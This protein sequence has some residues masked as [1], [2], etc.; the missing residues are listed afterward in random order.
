M[1]YKVFIKET[2]LHNIES[3]SEAILNISESI[4]IAERYIDGLYK[5]IQKLS[6]YGISL[7]FCQNKDVVN[8]YGKYIRRMNYKKVAVLFYVD[9]DTIL[10][11]EIKFQHNIM[12]EIVKKIPNS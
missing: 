12:G 9:N 7:P 5:E 4:N 8:M 1:K 2:A 3:I 6:I 10:V 11:Q